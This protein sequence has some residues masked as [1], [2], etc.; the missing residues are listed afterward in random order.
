MPTLEKTDVS[1]DESGMSMAWRLAR[2]GAKARTTSEHAWVAV[3]PA[4]EYV[5]IGVELER[6]GLRSAFASLSV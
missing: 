6:S 1:F 5:M 3:E 2:V 4:A